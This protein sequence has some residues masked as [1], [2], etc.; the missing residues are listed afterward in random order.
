MTDPWEKRVVIDDSILYQG[1]CVPIMEALDP[2]DATVTDPPYGIN[3]ASTGTIGG[4]TKRKGHRVEAKDYGKADWDKEGLTVEQWEAIQKVAPLWIV[5]GGNHL[6]GVLGPSAGVLVWDKKCKNGWNDTFSDGEMA[7]TNTLARAKI[8]RHL[9]IGMFRASEKGAN[10][11]QH[12]T[13]KPVA[14]MEWCLDFVEGKTIIDPFMGSGTTGV[15]CVNTGRKFIGIE[16]EP[17]YFEI[18]CKRIRG[19]GL[20]TDLFIGKAEAP[21]AIQDSMF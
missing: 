20:Q 7:W 19:A 9:W 4:T 3:I 5:W 2:V 16:R 12:P 6:A 13:Q 8:F 18:S 14:L 21:E 1:D 17:K 11:R 10:E 15:A